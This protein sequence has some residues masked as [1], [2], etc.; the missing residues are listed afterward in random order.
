MNLNLSNENKFL[1]WVYTFYPC[2]S[3]TTIVSNLTDAYTFALFIGIF[4]CMET[5]LKQK[6]KNTRHTW[7]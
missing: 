7:T 4:L 6:L 3:L 5:R 2:I 1:K